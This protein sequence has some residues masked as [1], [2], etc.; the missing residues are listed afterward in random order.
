MEP[1]RVVKNLLDAPFPL[2]LPP[3]E[4]KYARYKEFPPPRRGTIGGGGRV[5]MVKELLGHNTSFW[6]NRSNA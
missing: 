6:E 3:R 2:P 4:G 1:L 5:D